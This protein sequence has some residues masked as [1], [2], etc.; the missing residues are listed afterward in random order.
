MHHESDATAMLRTAMRYALTMLAIF[1]V[2]ALY[3]YTAF[4]AVV[5]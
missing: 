5:R 1:G 2:L 3:A 4:G